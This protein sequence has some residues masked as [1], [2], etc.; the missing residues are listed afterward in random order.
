[1][2]TEI[3]LFFINLF[4]FLVPSIYG[5]LRLGLWIHAAVNLKFTLKEKSY[6][7][8]SFKFLWFP[9]ENHYNDLDPLFALFVKSLHPFSIVCSAL[10][11]MVLLLPLYSLNTPLLSLGYLASLVVVS[12]FYWYVV[13]TRNKNIQTFYVEQKLSG[14]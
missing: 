12:S 10:I 5:L 8:E 13:V 2:N 14:D 4:I 11:L 7:G 9:P 3:N 1:M 6:S